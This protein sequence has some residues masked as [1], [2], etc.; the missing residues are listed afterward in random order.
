[1]EGDKILEKLEEHDGHFKTIFK[2]LDE[3]DCHFQEIDQQFSIIADCFAKI[4]GDIAEIRGDIVGI[5]G[6]IVEIKDTM[7]TKSDFNGGIEQLVYQFKYL[8]DEYHINNGR[9]KRIETHLGI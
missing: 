1:M 8:T 3:H 4:N 9:L 6:D 2:K 7:L 5:K